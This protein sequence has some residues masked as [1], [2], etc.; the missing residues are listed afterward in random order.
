MSTYYGLFCTKCCDRRVDFVSRRGDRFIWV[1]Q[2]E[3]TEFMQRHVD[4]IGLLEIISEDDP[5][6][7]GVATDEDEDDEVR[8]DPRTD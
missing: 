3:V 2:T 6:W 4:H 5:R 7:D 1:A 8:H